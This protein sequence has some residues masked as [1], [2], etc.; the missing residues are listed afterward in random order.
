MFYK[1]GIDITNAKQMFNFL[2]NHFQYY[3]MSS[4]N[5]VKSIANN[6]KLY[7]LDLDGDWS[8]ALQYLQETDYFEIDQMLED[9]EADHPNYVVGFNG[10]SGGYLVLC[11][12]NNTNNILPD[13]ITNF[14]TYEEFKEYLKEYWGG[15]KYY[16]ENLRH[17]TKVVQDFDKLCDSIRALINDYITNKEV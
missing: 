4:W 12:K 3:T 2:K 11:N 17:Y 9:W 15:V 13:T 1:K 14:D 6:V 8:K 10:H 5:K 7:N 16:L